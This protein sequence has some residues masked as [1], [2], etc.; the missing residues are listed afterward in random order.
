MKKLAAKRLQLNPETI[1]T[2]ERADLARAGGAGPAPVTDLSCV[3][4]CESSG[5]D[6]RTAQP[7]TAAPSADPVCR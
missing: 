4:V 5:C 6:P 2:L 7:R 3:L 1:R